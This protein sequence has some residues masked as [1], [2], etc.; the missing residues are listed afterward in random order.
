VADVALSRTDAEPDEDGVE[1]VG[2]F[3][4]DGNRFVLRSAQSGLLAVLA[5]RL[6]DLRCPADEPGAGGNGDGAPDATVFRIARRGPHWLDHPWGLW[7]DGEPC[8]TTVTDDYVVPYVLWEVTRLVLERA[9]PRIPVHAAAVDRD[10]RGVI[11]VAPSHAGKSTLSAWLT[12]SGWGFLTDELALIDVDDGPGATIHPFWRPVGVRRGGPLDDVIDSPGHE[13]EVLVPAS[14]L[15]RL[16]GPTPLA[17]IVC[18]AYTAGADGRVETLSP[19][20]ALA[21]VTAQLPELGAG[22]GTDAFRRFAGLVEQ[23]PSFAIGVDDLDTA[24]TA[25]AELDDR[26][27]VPA[28]ER[29]VM[30]R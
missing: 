4:A 28:A 27:P 29:E 21:R 11:L 3:V 30:G 26:L 20:A 5:D 15:G 24:A 23:V 17:A 10:G 16:A 12:R 1:D 8:E 18:P 2:P 25:L 22:R 7:R 9:A 13:D 19:A 6:R 14:E